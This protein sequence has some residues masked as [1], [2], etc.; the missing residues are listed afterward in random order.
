VCYYGSCIPITGCDA[1]GTEADAG[2]DAPEGADVRPEADAPEGADVRPEADAVP[3][4][5]A[6]ADADVAPDTVTDTGPERDAD[7]RPDVVPDVRPDAPVDTG[8][9]RN[10]GAPC[11]WSGECTGPD[12]SCL[13]TVVTPYGDLVFSN[14]YCISACD[15]G[16]GCGPDGVCLDMTDW[17]FYPVCMRAC[18]PGGG[19]WECRTDERYVC[20]NYYYLPVYFCGPPF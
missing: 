15:A 6:G 11:S 14:G 19:G 10:T 17:G 7:A 13:G 16:G 4:G 18:D 9:A 2:A 1:G 12:A 5:E 8:T 3:E 20:T